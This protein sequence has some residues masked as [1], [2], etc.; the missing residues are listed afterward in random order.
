MSNF[1]SLQRKR[2]LARERVAYIDE[3]EEKLADCN[4]R[5]GKAMQVIEAYSEN[6]GYVPNRVASI[7]EELDLEKENDE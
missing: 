5:L 2:R 6:E 3:L 1:D 7:M 4:V